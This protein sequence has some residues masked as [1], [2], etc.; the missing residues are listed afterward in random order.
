LYHFENSG[1]LVTKTYKKLMLMVRKIVLS[2]VAILS[3]SFAAVAQNKQ[4]TGT[5]KDNGGNP[6]AG[7]LILVDGTTNLG[8]VSEATGEFKLMAPANGV[9]NVSFMGFKSLQVPIAGKTKIDIVMEVD[10][11]AMDEVVVTAF[12]QTTKEAFTG[13]AAVVKS[14][15]IA[16]VQ[17]SNVAQSL[18]GRVAGVQTSS[19][20]GDLTGKPSIRIRGFSSINASQSPLWVVDGVPYEGD[21][22]NINPAD[23]ESMTVLKDAASNALYGARGANGVIMVTTKKAKRGEA[24][25]SFD[26]KWGVNSKALR[27]YEVIKSPELYYETHYKSLYN[28]HASNGVANAYEAAASSLTGNATGGLGY[29]VYSVPEGQY[30][31][32]RNGK[33]NPNATLGNKVSYNGEEYLLM[34]DDWMDEA[35]DNAFRQEYNVNIAGANE[36]SNFYASLGY[37]DNTGIIKSSEMQRYTARLKADYQ[38]KKWLKVGANMSYA[39]FESSNGNSDEGSSSSTGNIFA[40]ASDMAPIYPLYIRNADGSKKIDDYGLEMYDYGN[41][42]NAGLVRPNLP[43]ANAL[44]TSWLNKY[45]S[46]GNAFTAN[47]FADFDIYEGL[48]LTVNGSTTIDETR[49]LDMNNPYYGQFE[50]QGGTMYKYHTRSWVYNFQQLLTYNKTFAD[51]HNMDLLLGHEYYRTQYYYLRGGRSMLYSYDSEELSGAVVDA[52]AAYSY[53]TDYNNE[54]YFFRGQYN[55]DERYFFSAS[56]RRDASSK[57]HP[58]NR[59]GNFWSVGA[60]WIIDKENWFNADWVNLLKVKASFGSQG[61]DGISSNLYT[62]TYSVE[63][64]NGQVAVLFNSKG[65]KDI[66][67]ETNTNLNIGA[68]F[69]FWDNRLAGSFEFFNRNTTDMLFY[70]TVPASLGYNGYYANVGDM[71]NRGIELELNGDI[72][73]TKNVTWSAS[74]NMTHVANKVTALADQYKNQTIE[75]YNGYIDGSYYVAEDLPLYSFYMRE[76]AGV[77]DKGESTWWQDVWDQREIGKNPDGS[78]IMED[79]IKERVKTTDYA[80]A[81][82]YIQESALPDVYG[83]FSTSVSAFGFDASIAFTYQLGGLVYDSGYAQFMSSPYGSFAGSNYHKD[84]LN[85]WSQDNKESNIPRLQYGDQYSTGQSDRFLTSASYLNIQNINVGYTLPADWTKKFGVSSLRVYLACDNVVYWSKRRGL[86]PRYSFSGSTNFANYSPIR[87]I[88]GGLNVVF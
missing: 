64:N 35:Y 77:N 8:T 81:S 31:I 36:R 16:K 14:D 63:N 72:I 11:K 17:S 51:K 60:S 39:H 58:D 75:G 5:V 33:L 15:D 56:F 41:K 42:G 61:N 76:Y 9:L 30:L 37:L 25:V 24:K 54:G 7:A 4:V 48:K 44:Q 18:V 29:N 67:W 49:T 55:Y 52:A 78:P 10:S 46:E 65:N 59:W 88:S 27:E 32:G 20:S 43:D 82:R 23:I 45:K 3:L 19:S 70:F 50:E 40:F 85:S 47:G 38:A 86:D 34:P 21:L 74:L 69:G 79:Y 83:G 73:R 1:T 2:I 84:I 12:G 87:T 28:Y 13:S 53:T 80:N 26:A 6:I 68:E 62:D 57:F 71:F 22:N 66:T